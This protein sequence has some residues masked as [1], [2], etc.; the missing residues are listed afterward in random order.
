MAILYIVGFAKKKLAGATKIDTGNE[1]V[2]KSL[3]YGGKASFYLFGDYGCVLDSR[4]ALIMTW[5]DKG[6]HYT[7]Y[8]KNR[9]KD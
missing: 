3:A 1:S 8:F 7:S 4:F 9:Y 6:D 2:A 5:D